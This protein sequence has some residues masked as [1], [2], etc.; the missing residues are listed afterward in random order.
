MPIFEDCS[1]PSCAR[2]FAVS[3]VSNEVPR[4]SASGEVICPHCKTISRKMEPDFM[5]T[6][7]QRFVV[8]DPMPLEHENALR[9]EKGLAPLD[10]GSLI[11]LCEGE[12]EHSP[13]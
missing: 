9:Q 10:T 13:P 12:P 4:S 8:T 3:Q 11:V 2:P 6:G 1:N 5:P 7:G